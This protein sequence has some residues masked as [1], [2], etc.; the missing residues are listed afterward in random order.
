MKKA[1][2]LAFAIVLFQYVFAQ[3]S[4]SI[5]LNELITAYANAGRFNGSVLVAQHGNILLQK[6]YGIKSAENNSQ[7]DA[8]TIFQIASIT[9]QFTATVILKLVELRKMSLQ[10]K[11]SQY[12]SGF[13]YGDSITIEHLLT[14]TSGLRNFTEEDSSI[15]ETDEPRMVPYL[16]TLKP[17]FAPGT[18]W[19][20]S[21]SGYVMLGYIIQKVSGMSYWQAVR[22]YIFTPLQMN[23][24]GF[25][26]RHLTGDEKAVGYDIL[27]D[28]VKQGSVITDSTVPFGAG[29][30]YSTVQDMYKWHLGL[31]S[32][33]IVGKALLDKAYTPCP[34]HKYGYG[35]QIDSVYGR[36]MV[37][38]SGSISGFGSNF[39]R[40]PGDDIC[41]VLLSNE[42]GS[43]S[44]V[45]HITDKLLAVMYNKPY[46]VPVKRIPVSVAQ[47]VLQKYI[48]TYK[49]DEIN[50]TVDVTAGDGMLIAQPNRDGHPGPTS[51]L[52]PLNDI[53]FYDE[54][55]EDVEVTFDVDTAGKVNGMTI[56]QM[57]ITKYAKKTK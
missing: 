39:A 50:V 53:H 15:T 16:K 41:I 48:G 38:H 6:G 44:E 3:D 8:G 40:I 24:S 42:S 11:L 22:M 28:S 34:Q 43:T 30:I 33:Q 54:H 49:I 37:S 47:D 21:N 18:D 12:Y 46:N 25:D 4:T 7:N 9:K 5:K 45:R 52:H 13:P 51:F 35:W 27:N 31:Q 36:K 57:G 2:I 14:H 20:Y 17:D 19:H 55:D 29:S 26:F 10:D 56:L 32:Y 23:N 1:I